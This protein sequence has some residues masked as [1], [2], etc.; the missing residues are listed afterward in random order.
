MNLERKDGE[1][2]KM[3]C[4]SY[5][6]YA[7]D[8][9]RQTS[10]EDQKQ[11]CRRFAEE[12]GW[13]APDQHV[14]T[15]AGKPGTSLAGR[16]GLH[17]LIIAAQSQPSP[18]RM[19]L[20]EDKSRLARNPRDVLDIVDAL[21]LHGVHVYFINQLLDSRDDHTRM[22]LMLP[23]MVKEQYIA[24]LSEKVRRGQMGRVIS[25][26]TP[27]GRCFGYRSVPVEATPSDDAK[28]RGE[29]LGTRLEIVD[30]EAETV[31][32]IYEMFASGVAVPEM[33][34]TLNA[35]QVAVAKIGK[36]N[37]PWTQTRIRHILRQERHVGTVAWNRT[38]R[39]RNPRTGRVELHANPP[40]DVLRVSAPQL[41]I[42]TDE[43]WNRVQARLRAGQGPRPASGETRNS[44]PR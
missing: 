44:T 42:V 19:V 21:A 16:D 25:G 18:F 41:R 1:P 2:D 14:Y 43:L 28:G 35:E 20:V 10:L 24:G 39:V 26:L 4:A 27:G 40:A 37:S 32:R 30:T 17:S 34:K 36:L 23:E 29:V 22:I 8:M 38:K 13:L 6:R 12:H 3:R 15:D 11:H 31:R 5:L 7:S 9:A 33:V